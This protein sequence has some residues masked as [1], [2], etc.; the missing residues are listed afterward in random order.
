MAWLCFSPLI[1]ATRNA[2]KL[3]EF[4][5]LLAAV[6]EHVIGLEAFTGIPSVAETGATF[7]ENA[8]IKARTV[9]AATGGCV[10]ADDSGLCV[11]ALD[12]APGVYSARYAG[13][14]ASDAENIAKLLAALRDVPPDQRTAQF[15]C[16]LALVTDTEE[17]CFTGLCS[18]VIA[19]EP[20]GQLG[21]GYDPLFIPEGET[22]TFAEMTAAEKA[23]Y[24]HRAR[25]V[26]A[27][28]THLHNQQPSE[29][30]STS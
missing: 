21:F 1:I 6:T 13:E 30:F 22:R 17:R 23:R 3:S 25:A 27:L 7:A 14:Q 5:D 10:L 18:G 26:E 12:G 19:A 9:R 28:I 24:S 29:G 8:L 15:V 4:R 11:D 20:R 2:G 16:V